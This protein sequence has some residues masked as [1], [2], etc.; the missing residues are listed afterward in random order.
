MLLRAV[1][2][3]MVVVTHTDLWLIPGGA[4]V[5]LAVAGFN[6]ARFT[7]RVDGRRARARRLVATLAAVAVPAS[8]WI[9]GC[10]LVTGDY[11]I[12]TA[13]YLNGVVGSGDWSHGLAVLV[14]RSPGL[15]VPRDRRA[16]LPCGAS[17][18]GSGRTRSRWR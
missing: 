4:H 3:V 16:R 7:L 5:L 9:A 18:G 13:V 17:T 14:P 15:G 6:L 2:I 10:A 12:S 1:A 11:R 8:A